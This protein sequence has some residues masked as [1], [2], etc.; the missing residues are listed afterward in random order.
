MVATILHHQAKRLEGEELLKFAMDIATQQSSN[1][2][3]FCF[4]HP[5]SATSWHLDYVQS[6]ARLPNTKVVAFDQCQFGLTSTDSELLMMK[7]TRLMT[8][9]TKVA[10]AFMNKDPTIWGSRCMWWRSLGSV[11]STGLI[12]NK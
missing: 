6:V 8:N 1:G 2:G 10:A 3:F 11:R 7:R 9:S 12:V 4:E 5:E